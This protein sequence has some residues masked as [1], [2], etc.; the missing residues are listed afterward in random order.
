MQGR[1]RPISRP[2]ALR[3]EAKASRFS[4]LPLRTRALKADR[5]T[6]RGTAT[7]IVYRLIFLHRCGSPMH[8]PAGR[9]RPRPARDCHPIGRR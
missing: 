5:Q 8:P 6:T 9:R 1:V 2:V 3:D 4:V 7:C